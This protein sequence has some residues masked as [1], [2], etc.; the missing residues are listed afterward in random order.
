ME[1]PGWGKIGRRESRF[2]FFGRT[3]LE[4]QKHFSILAPLLWHVHWKDLLK[5]QFLL[6][7]QLCLSELKIAMGYIVLVSYVWY[8]SIDERLSTLTFDFGLS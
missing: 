1:R 5:L 3:I 6:Q 2:C 4:K 7:G 8:A